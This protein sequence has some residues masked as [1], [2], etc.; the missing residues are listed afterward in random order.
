MP[1]P[2]EIRGVWHVWSHAT[3]AS[4]M[5]AGD[6]PVGMDMP[7]GY[8]TTKLA[9]REFRLQRL[10]QLFPSKGLLEGPSRAH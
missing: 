4:W 7:G 3:G 6:W 9:L 1:Q 5:A 8:R 10:K 2:R